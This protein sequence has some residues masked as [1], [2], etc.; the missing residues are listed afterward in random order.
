MMEAPMTASDVRTL[1]FTDLTDQLRRSAP[2]L[3]GVCLVCVDGPSG[4]G[5]TTLA[6]HLAATSRDRL[7]VD[8]V[9]LDDVYEGW[10]GLPA[11]ADRL[12]GWL[13]GPLRAGRPGGYHRYDWYAGQYAD[14]RPVPTDTELLILEG[15]GS[16]AAGAD[17]AVLRLWVD[18][19][20]AIR[21]RRGLD[22]DGETFRPHWEAWADA[23]RAHFAAHDSPD[24]AD[25]RIDGAP[26]ID[27]DPERELVVVDDSDTGVR[28]A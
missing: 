14:W 28:I 7:R 13:L 18:A 9:H 24:R 20:R 16:F 3:P 1:A 23:E 2:R 22:R 19:P 27:Y 17:D 25:L 12:D 21:L 26:S 6:T 8:V 11:V 5:K 4:A 10:D 15:V